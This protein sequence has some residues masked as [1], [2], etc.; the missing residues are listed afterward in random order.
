VDREDET[1]A[2]TVVQSTVRAPPDQAG[3][4]SVLERMAFRAQVAHEDVATARRKAEAVALDRLGGD[5]TLGEVRAAARARC[6]AELRAEER[7]GCRV[8]GDQ[9]LAALPR[10]AR[11]LGRHG[12]PETLG[13]CPHGLGEGQ[14]LRLHDEAEDVAVLAAAEAVIEAA[15][16][17]HRERRRLL[18]V[19]RTQTG[20]AAA[21]ALECHDIADDVRDARALA[22]LSNGVFSDEPPGH[23]ISA[24][25]WTNVRPEAEGFRP[26]GGRNSRTVHA[27]CVR[28]DR[29]TARL[30]AAMAFF[31][32]RTLGFS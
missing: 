18:G 3:G 29:R 23:R 24:P 25:R 22:D 12:K 1:V 9:R 4:R 14:R 2:E 16:F 5:G 13:H 31:F 28:E 30:R 20:D 15:L 32:R 10:S 27:T 8:D 26:E 7:R 11:R 17:A 19:E 6:A 21:A